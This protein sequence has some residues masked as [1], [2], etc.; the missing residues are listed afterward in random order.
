VLDPVLL[1]SAA[2]RFRRSVASPMSATLAYTA[3][4][5]LGL[6][7]AVCIEKMPDVAREHLARV[8]DWFS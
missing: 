1:R 8:V 3:L 2:D 5:L 6:V 4:C 7:F